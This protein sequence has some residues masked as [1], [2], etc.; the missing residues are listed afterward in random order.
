MSS[1]PADISINSNTD[2]EKVS[3]EKQHVR[4]DSYSSSVESISGNSALLWKI[5]RTILPILTL[6]YLI[7]FLDRSNIGNA[8]LENLTTDLHIG[9]NAYL[10]TLTI[11]F[12]GYV[13]FEVPSNI[14]LKRF[15]PRIWL[16]TLM[17]IWG[18]VSIA[19]GLVHNFQGLLAA[20]FFLGISE[21]GLFPGVVWYMSMWYPRSLQHYRI[22]LFFS[23]ASLSGAFGGILAFAIGKMKGVGGKAGW[24][25][26]FIIEGLFTVVVALAAFFLIHDFPAKAKFLN[27]SE[28][29]IWVDILRKSGDAADEEPFTWGNVANALT[30]FSVWLY[31]GLFVG[32][33]LP[34]YTL[35]LFLPTIIK[36]MG[37]TAAQAQLLTVPPYALAFITTVTASH[38]SFKVNAR[39]PFIILA[40]FVASIGYIVLLTDHKTRAQYAGVMIAAAGIYPA[41]ALVLSWPANNI[42]GQTKRAVGCALQISVGISGGAVVGSQM[43]RPKQSPRYPLGHGMAMGFLALTIAIASLQALILSRRNKAKK[44]ARDAQTETVVEAPGI[45]DRSIYWK[46]VL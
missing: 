34:L 23:A 29:R 41:T 17:I 2:V 38:L 32:M 12:F 22:S 33:S 46:Y 15:S 36:N 16:P 39:S 9:N 42:S 18:I 43:Y 6:L 25:W 7:S 4:A 40:C 3:F 8:R 11:Y 1:R 19:M 24:A 10:W 35:S 14:I 28:R 13:I 31:A 27:E 26:I 30:D 21:A 45:G 44:V 37:F 20:R 5:D